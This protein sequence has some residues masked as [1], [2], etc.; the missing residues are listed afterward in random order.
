MRP[1]VTPRAGDPL[2]GLVNLFD[3]GIVLA[4]AFLLAALQS[5]NLSDLLTKS[6]VTLLRTQAGQQ[7]LIV[8]DGDKIKT[9]RLSK[10]TSRAPAR[11]SGRSTASLTD[12]SSTCRP[13]SPDR[14]DRPHGCGRSSP[15]CSRKLPRTV[16]DPRMQ[17]TKTLIPSSTDTDAGS[18]RVHRLRR[19]VASGACALAVLAAPGVAAAA[20][21]LVAADPAVDQ[22][23]AL[24]GVVVWSSGTFGDRVLMQRSRS[25]M[26]AR[27]EG[28]P[29]AAR[30]SERSTSGAIARTGSC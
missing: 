29:R 8:K 26:I 3:L 1:T 25:G 30:Y 24:D 2:D 5:V 27:V 14:P 23:A 15:R 4:V 10:K 19:M 11:R 28:A 16:D 13:R 7:T 18:Q 22:V 21:T 17:P 20:D 6:N 12:G 9:V